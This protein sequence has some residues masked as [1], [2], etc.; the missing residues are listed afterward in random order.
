MRIHLSSALAAL[1]LC[2]G[3]S[4]GLAAT[5]TGSFSSQLTI[6]ADCQVS[7][8]NL[9]FGSNGVLNA[10]LNTTS[11][12]SVQCTNNQG[13]KISLNGGNGTSGTVAVRTMELGGSDAVSFV[14]YTMATDVN[15]TSNW[16]NTIGT[17]TVP[18]TGNGAVQN[19]TVYGRVQAQTTPVAGSYSDLVTVTVTY[20]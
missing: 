14:N 3:A 18:G 4:S 13:Y 10:A 12:I 2:L 6:T 17:D 8:T 16:G 7:A 11:T 9:N 1:G 20:P 15:Q 5:A 19:Y